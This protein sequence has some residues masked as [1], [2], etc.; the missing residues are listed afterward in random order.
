MVLLATVTIVRAP[1]DLLFR[2]PAIMGIQLI[3]GCLQGMYG[4]LY[5]ILIQMV[6]IMELT[7]VKK[8]ERVQGH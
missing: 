5:S 1:S 2:E 7:L 8:C 4:A 3:S 6:R